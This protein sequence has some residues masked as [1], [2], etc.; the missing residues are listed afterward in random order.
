MQLQLLGD[1]VE[2]HF[3]GVPHES[4]ICFAAYVEPSIALVKA[5]VTSAA[6]SRFVTTE[7]KTAPPPEVEKTQILTTVV[8][9]PTTLTE[10]NTAFEQTEG[11]AT[12]RVDT[13][14]LLFGK[15]DFEQNTM[16]QTLDLVIEESTAPVD[17]ENNSDAVDRSRSTLVDVAPHVSPRRM[18][19]PAESVEIVTIR[20]LVAELRQEAFCAWAAASVRNPRD[21]L[22]TRRSF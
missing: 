15:M 22:E 3:S 13:P 5:A 18:S 1:N 21:T 10:L 8:A 17:L 16:G 4:T 12:E 20:E 19:P 14:T 6:N 7:K 9:E 2:D 11:R